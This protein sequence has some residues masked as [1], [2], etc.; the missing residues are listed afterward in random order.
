VTA[1]QMFFFAGSPSP[2]RSRSTCFPAFI[3]SLNHFACLMGWSSHVIRSNQ[4]Y[5]KRLTM[6]EG[7]SGGFWRL[8]WINQSSLRSLNEIEVCVQSAPKERR[9]QIER[10]EQQDKRVGSSQ[11]ATRRAPPSLHALDSAKSLFEQIQ[12]VDASPTDRVKVAVGDVRLQATSLIERWKTIL[13][14][15]VAALNNEL[16]TAGLPRI[17]IAP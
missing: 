6:A 9:R 11:S 1:F 4:I 13:A 3:T 2:R 10:A 14:Q 16:Q 8:D 5:R 17:N 7:S 12:G 15:D